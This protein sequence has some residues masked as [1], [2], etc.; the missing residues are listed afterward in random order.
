MVQEKVSMIKAGI[1]DFKNKR[2]TTVEYCIQNGV[3][4]AHTLFND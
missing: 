3:F 1:Y 4:T 2:V